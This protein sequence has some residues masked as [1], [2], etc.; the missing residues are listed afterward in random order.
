MACTENLEDVAP[1]GPTLSTWHLE[2]NQLCLEMGPCAQS[3]ALP[4]PP[5][6]Y[7]S[8]RAVRNQAP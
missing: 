8:S 6:H 2:K 4:W 5:W 1:L 7:K 3:P